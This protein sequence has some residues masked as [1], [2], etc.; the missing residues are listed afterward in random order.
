MRNVI[1]VHGS[2]HASW[3]WAL[4]T[5]QLA[6]RGVPSVAVDMDGH[7]L[8][9]HSPASRWSRPFDP[10]A[11]V[12]ERSSVADVT[13]ASAAASLL[14]QI[15]QIG[16][17]EPCVV[18][19]HSMSGVIATAAAEQEP[20]LFAALVYLAAFAP[21]AG[22]PAT[23]YESDAVSDTVSD[24]GN[25]GGGVPA[26]LAADPAAV[27][28][29]R[30]DVGDPE[31]HALIRET[32]FNDVEPGLADAAV[33]L[34]TPDTPLAIVTESPTVTAARY[35]AVP[36]AYIT[37]AKDNAIPLD[38]QRRFIREIDAISTTPTQV[39]DLDSSH[40]PF[41]SQPATLADAI[42]AVASR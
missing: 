1:L 18:V 16:R 24:T 20:S 5:P 11:F 4:I 17:G 12:T 35:G 28:T 2:W 9:A 26:L 27:G 15:R 31:R 41:L 34:L 8:A 38:V 42:A 33:G 36:H 7:G 22:L 3:C 40:S 37:C 39:F 14:A 30:I 21:V 32:F 29:F 23:A 13:I 19:A 10:A 6:A 25:D